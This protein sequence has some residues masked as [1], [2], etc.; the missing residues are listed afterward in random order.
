M[1]NSRRN[2]IS[3]KKSRGEEVFWVGNR[4]SYLERKEDWLLIKMQ[5]GVWSLST[6]AGNYSFKP[7]VCKKPA[8]NAVMW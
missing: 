2:H 7:G 1:S 3:Q 6:S 4:E 8:G 5:T